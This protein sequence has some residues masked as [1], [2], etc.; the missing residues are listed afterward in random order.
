MEAWK[1]AVISEVGN[2]NDLMGGLQ[3]H[4]SAQYQSTHTPPLLVKGNT[5]PDPFLDDDRKRTALR[6]DSHEQTSTDSPGKR[7]K[8]DGLYSKLVLTDNPTGNLIEQVVHSESRG[9]VAPYEASSYKSLEQRGWSRTAVRGYGSN[10][11]HGDLLR[12]RNMLR[13]TKAGL[14]E[15]TGAKI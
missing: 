9:L 4:S 8:R 7:T 11:D 10:E 14:Q 3:S 13:G 15:D 6:S 5:P 2:R 12:W 1:E